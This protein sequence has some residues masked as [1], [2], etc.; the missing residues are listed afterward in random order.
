M[1]VILLKDVP[2]IGKKGDIKNISDG[3]ARNFLIP[4]KLAGPATES[5]IREAETKIIKAQKNKEKELNAIKSIFEKFKDFQLT[6]QEKASEAGHLFAGV[7]EK[8]IASE[9][10]KRGINN[11]D[12]KNIKLSSPI[13][14]LGEHDVEIKKEGERGLIKLIIKAD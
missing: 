12:P 8:R 13:K 6:I 5:S 3:Y 11:I 4:N 2:K 9:L 1:R 14:D 7:D 10:K